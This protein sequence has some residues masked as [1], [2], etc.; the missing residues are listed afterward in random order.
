MVGPFAGAGPLRGFG[1]G[2][3]LLSLPCA[4]VF[5]MTISP[6]HPP[7][8]PATLAERLRDLGETAARAARV[9]AGGDYPELAIDELLYGVRAAFPA[10]F[11][12]PARTAGRG[13]EPLA[14]QLRSVA[15]AAARAAASVRHACGSA[16]ALAAFQARIGAVFPDG[17]F[18]RTPITRGQLARI[19][20]AAQDASSL[21]DLFVSAGDVAG[22]R[23]AILAAF[24]D[25]IV[26]APG[27]ATSPRTPDSAA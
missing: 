21:G 6:D 3:R 20:E 12:T 24:P 27:D 2:K 19:E 13:E 15:G 16:E 22:L 7:G 17:A 14:E 4:R 11:P 26:P 10:G 18:E 9:A 1:K 25:G 8:D 5:D 23:E